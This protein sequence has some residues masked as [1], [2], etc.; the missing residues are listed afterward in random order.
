M[1]YKSYSKRHRTRSGR[2]S[3]RDRALQHIREAEELSAELGGTDE[4]VKAY[5]FSLSE[6]ELRKVLA[7]YGQAF[8]QDK[9]E[10]A[11]KTFYLWRGGHRKMSGL[12]AG[13]LYSLLPRRMPLHTKYAMV[14]TLWTKYSPKSDK[15]LLI[16][17]DASPEDVFSQLVEHACSTIQSYQVP[18]PMQRRFQWLS[19]GDVG[20]YQQLLNHF[21]REDLELAVATVEAKV[22][23]FFNHIRSNPSLN[24]QFTE[25]IQ[26]G[27]HRMELTFSNRFRGISVGSRSSGSSGA[28]DNGCLWSILTVGG[29]IL[30]LIILGN[31]WA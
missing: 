29:I 11:E 27:G 5:F 10:Y 1:A 30:L 26:V 9:R 17:P 16:G 6:A 15:R 25:T 20:V 3:G 23:I 31:A 28:D 14:K 2:M 24:Q 22:P 4:D 12:V 19:D 18:E 13:R 8:G 7:E 21:L